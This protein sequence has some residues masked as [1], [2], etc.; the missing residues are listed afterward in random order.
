MQNFIFFSL[1]SISCAKKNTLISLDQL[2]PHQIQNVPIGMSKDDFRKKN[3]AEYEEISLGNNITYLKKPVQSPE[4][5]FIQYKFESE[6][7]A[8]VLI[9]YRA[10]FGAKDIATS[11]Y[12]PP[13][14]SGRWLATSSN[15]TIT[16]E[17]IDNAIVYH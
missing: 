13:N 15:Q 14:D 10:S 1:L 3:P 11:L 4:L 9:G 6:N 17:I 2:L 5:L 12:G 16:I 7:L 8:E